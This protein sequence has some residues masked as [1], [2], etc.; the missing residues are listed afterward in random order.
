MSPG[1]WMTGS[2]TCGRT[3]SPSVFPRTTGPSLPLSE[4]V[5]RSRWSP[6]MLPNIRLSRSPLTLK[7]AHDL[8]CTTLNLLTQGLSSINSCTEILIANLQHRG[9]LYS[10]ISRFSSRACQVANTGHPNPLRSVIQ[11]LRVVFEEEKSI[12][13]SE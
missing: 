2:W 3:A 13:R 1:R 8:I 12:V 11:C 4:S 5:G 10:D 6:Q 9:L 7:T